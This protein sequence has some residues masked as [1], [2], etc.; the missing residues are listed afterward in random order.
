MKLVDGKL[1]ADDFVVP[2]QGA[3]VVPTSP[4]KVPAKLTTPAV[5]AAPAKTDLAKADVPVEIQFTK[6]E[7]TRVVSTNDKLKMIR[8]CLKLRG[9]DSQQLVNAM[10]EIKTILSL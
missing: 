9:L 6:A 10:E 5:S 1:V 2:V 8:S 3:T 4:A 7:V